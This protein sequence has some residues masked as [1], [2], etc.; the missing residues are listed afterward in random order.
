[1]KVLKYIKL[2]FGFD[3]IKMQKDVQALPGEYWQKHYNTKD[4]C[5]EWLA[6]PLRSALGSSN[7][8]IA[9][10][11][12][13][14]DFA[15]TELMDMCPYIKALTE[16]F[17][18]PK[19]SVRLLNLK[20]GAIVYPHRDKDLYFEE[21]EARFHIPVIT[22]NDI[23]FYLDT[24]QIFLEEGSCWYLNLALTHSLQ[25]NSTTDRIHLVIDC[26]VND[27]VKEQFIHPAIKIKKTVKLKNK[28]IQKQQTIEALLLMNTTFSNKL[29]AEMLTE[30]SSVHA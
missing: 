25:N 10:S 12:D 11:A 13:D 9:H 4:Y 20:A 17:D 14:A 2:P 27:W 15:D 7:N 21:G 30:I 28:I 16:S 23:K 1:M 8:I 22:N 18:C 29:A 3:I 26:V 6:L 24:E 5:G 19:L